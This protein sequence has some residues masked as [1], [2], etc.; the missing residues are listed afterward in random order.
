[1]ADNVSIDAEF[2]ISLIKMGA[3][4]L[5]PRNKSGAFALRG[6]PGESEK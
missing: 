6:M 1:V 4:K 2:F 3:T 5:N